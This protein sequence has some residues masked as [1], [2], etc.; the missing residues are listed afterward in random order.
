MEAV[1]D[2]MSNIRLLLLRPFYGINVHGDM[3]GD[4]GISD[5]L[6]H[7]YPDLSFIYA[8]TIA[9]SAPWVDLHVID[10]NL[11]RFMPETVWEKLNDFYDVIVIK[12]LAPTVRY[13]LDFARE[14]KK[15]YPF[16]KVVLAGHVASLIADWIK[17]K[18]PIIDEVARV[19]MEFY[20]YNLIYGEGDIHI[21]DLP[22]PNFSLFP[23]EGFRDMDGNLRG[24][25][26]T[27]R[28]CAVGCDYCP[29]SS[30]YGRRMEFRSLPNVLKDIEY[31]L[32]LGIKE[33]LFRD[34]YFSIR[35]KRTEE[36]CRMIIAHKLKFNWQC[37]TRLESLTPDLIDLMVEAGMDMVC[38]GVETASANTLNEYNRPP[39]DEAKLIKLIRYLHSKKVMTI[40]F[41]MI[42]FP[43]DTWHTIRP[44]YELATR[45]GSQSAKFSIY[46]PCT[47]AVFPNK[48]IT[49]AVFTPFDNTMVTN[50]CKNLSR[51][52][53]EFLVDHLTNLYHTEIARRESEKN[54]YLK[55]IYEYHF[56]HQLKFHN[57]VQNL[58]K[59]LK[60]NT[61]F[62]LIMHG[63]ARRKINAY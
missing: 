23:Y 10:A 32:S 57:R 25:L 8:A 27:S 12:A 16:S 24:S 37:E 54:N 20:M 42:G 50:P 30:F 29:Y 9:D 15:R 31:L 46:S 40:A 5:H 13:D 2:K 63:K 45:I 62:N 3:H 18:I 52:Q 59:R 33:I 58:K 14:I 19:P 47:P 60:D 49:P 26:Y 56:V 53:L 48:Q 39:V 35:P 61:I 41:Y 51:K 6:P 38:F 4:L 11:N 7:I 55:G 36:L 17:K 44:T 21:D 28:G 34:Q 1:K 22:I 43:H